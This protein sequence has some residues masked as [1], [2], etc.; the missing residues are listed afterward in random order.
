LLTQSLVTEISVVLYFR[1]PD[2]QKII[3]LPRNLISKN[4]FLWI[5]DSFTNLLKAI[6]TL[7]GNHTHHAYMFA[8]NLFLMQLSSSPTS[9]SR[10]LQHKTLIQIINNN[11]LDTHY[12]I[13]VQFSRSVVSDSLR[14]HEYKIDK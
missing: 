11:L 7:P 9:K 5:L 8:N 14:P 6:D 4:F 12:Y 2:I 13:S 3:F 10:S 1:K